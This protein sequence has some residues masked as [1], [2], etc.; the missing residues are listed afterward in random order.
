MSEN[1]VK[2]NFQNFFPRILIISYLKLNVWLLC[3]F[4]T[5]CSYT[6]VSRAF[7][8]SSALSVACVIFRPITSRSF[9]FEYCCF[10]REFDSGLFVRN[11]SMSY[12]MPVVLW[13]PPTPTYTCSLY[14]RY[15]KQAPKTN[16]F[17]STL[18]LY[19]KVQKSFQWS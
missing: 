5:R 12:W 6:F 1:K 19:F 16:Q 17:H 4:I 2:I 11:L 14:S 13:I 3:M 10:N 8:S 18:L 7:L 9:M 15:A